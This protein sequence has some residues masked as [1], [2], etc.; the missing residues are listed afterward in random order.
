MF[1]SFLTYHTESRTALNSGW[2]ESFSVMS[3][4]SEKLLERESVKQ[5]S[6]RA[7]N[8]MNQGQ[9]RQHPRIE[10][11]HMKKTVNRPAIKNHPF[12]RQSVL[13]NGPLAPSLGLRTA[14]SY[15]DRAE[16]YNYTEH[17]TELRRQGGVL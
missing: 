17:N 9:S 15:G 3:E 5:L 14:Q 16:C 11:Q 13:S 2:N 12:V 1:T 6:I 8:S 7:L 4:I 10:T